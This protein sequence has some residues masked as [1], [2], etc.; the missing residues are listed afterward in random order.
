MDGLASDS[1]DRDPLLM[2]AERRHSMLATWR[3]SVES[4]RFPGSGLG[5]AA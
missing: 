4:I 5:G 3:G 1:P 2:L